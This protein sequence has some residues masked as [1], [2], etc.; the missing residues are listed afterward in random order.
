[1]NRVRTVAAGLALASVVG[2]LTHRAMS[3]VMQPGRPDA[4]RWVLQDFRDAVYY[5]V[6]AWLDGGN[7]YDQDAQA[8]RYPVGQSFP[9]Y[10]PAT[11]VAHLPFGLLPPAEAAWAYF[12]TTLLLTGALAALALAGAGVPVTAAAVLALATVLLASRAGQMNLLLGQV[13]AQVVLASYVALRWA[14]SRPLLAGLGLALA[15]LKPTYGVPLAALMLLGRGDM[16]A[17]V[18]GVVASVTLCSVALVPLVHAQGGLAAFVASLDSSAAAFAAEDSS[19]AWGSVAR[20]DVSSLVARILGR[21]PALSTEVGLGVLVIAAA[22]VGLRRLRADRSAAG[23]QLGIGLVCLS[24]LVGFY[25]QTYDVLLLTWPAMALAAGRWGRDGVAPAALR[26]AV[27]GLIAIP[28]VNYLASVPFA[29][30]LTRG[31]PAW[32]TLTALNP[33][34]LLAAWGV[35]LALAARAAR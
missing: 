13:T 23:T 34:A 30:Q 24:I 18:A 5:P 9:L 6:V 1:V 27:L 25:H 28:F 11:L 35:H 17:T 20:T 7:P 33:A 12:A 2:F 26:W 14:R 22:V 19:N 32:L 15:T 3:L 29:A 10:L 21:A 16:R 4:A 31:G 8:R